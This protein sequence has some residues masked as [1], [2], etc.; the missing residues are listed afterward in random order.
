MGCIPYKPSPPGGGLGIF[1]S[2]GD[3]RPHAGSHRGGGGHTPCPPHLPTHLGLLLLHPPHAS[4]PTKGLGPTGGRWSVS[5]P[6]PIYVPCIPGSVGFS[7]SILHS[8][9]ARCGSVQGH[10]GSALPLPVLPDG[11][12][13]DIFPPSPPIFLQGGSVWGPP[14]N[15]GGGCPREMVYGR[16][17]YPKSGPDGGPVI[18]YPGLWREGSFQSLPPPSHIFQKR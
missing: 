15:L 6:S 11:K 16:S 9:P 4:L 1:G 17:S 12:G 8:C 10:C 2:T 13:R 3:P 7:P 18:L 14:C 5:R